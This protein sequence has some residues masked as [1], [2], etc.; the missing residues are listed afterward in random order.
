MKKISI[1]IALFTLFLLQS[2]NA[3]AQVKQGEVADKIIAVVGNDVI[4][5]SDLYAY[6]AQMA[7][8]DPKA[9][10]D[11][12]LLKERILT[13]LI[14]EKLMIAKAI[15]DS[16]S[17]SD[18]E[19]ETRWDYQVKRFV[20]RYGSEKR[21]EDIFGMS[22]A[23]MKSEYKDDIRKQII[24]EKMKNKLFADIKLPRSEVIDFYNNY[25]D[26]LPMAPASIELFHIVKNV[27][28]DRKSKEDIYELAKS[29]RDSILKGG[30]FADFAK[31]YSGDPG[32]AS[33]GGELGWV[34]KGKFVKEFEQAA[35]SQQ[36]GALSMPVETPFGFHLIETLDKGK[37][38]AKTRH[39]LFRFGQSQKDVD[40]VTNLLKDIKSKISDSLTFEELAKRYS[41]ETETKG[42]GGFIGQFPLEQL[43]PNI[44][45]AIAKMKDGEVSD[46]IIYSMDPKKV[47]HIIYRKRTIPEHKPTIK[48]DFKQIEMMATN[49][50]QNKIYTEWME[51]I[52]KEMYWEIK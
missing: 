24:A 5:Q 27:E 12:P 7:S 18:E 38:S 51:K 49:F 44:K 50:K 9:K 52:R 31:R 30:N 21:I 41:D 15:E 43:P 34:E 47:F 33:I 40:F 28:S 22:L 17:A 14:N 35:F 3:S 10:I 23:Q 26:S 4:T 39:I 13:M 42:F 11:D 46:P 8:Q 29:V 16:L 19:V 32:T 48:D 36:K 1:I 2:N 25:K 37:D 45:D 20:E 6:L